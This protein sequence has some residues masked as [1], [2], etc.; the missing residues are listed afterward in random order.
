M[1]VRRDSTHNL[2]VGGGLS[3]NLSV[4]WLSTNNLLV[5]RGLAEKL[6][7]RLGLTENLSSVR[8]H[9]T[10]ILS[11]RGGRTISQLEAL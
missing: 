9:F 6:S 5:K 11:V 3:K 4:R 10:Y 1:S 7:V 2:S 8:S